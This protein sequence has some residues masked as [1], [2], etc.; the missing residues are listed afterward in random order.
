MGDFMFYNKKILNEIKLLNLRLDEYIEKSNSKKRII[1]NGFIGGLAKGLGI[2]LGVVILG[3]T[4]IIVLKELISL[5]IIGK[6]IA[7]IV[8]YVEIYLNK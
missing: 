5:P 6:Y 4:L 3:A 2:S 1:V 8:H 7:Q